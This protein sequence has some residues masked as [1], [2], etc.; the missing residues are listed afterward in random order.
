MGN[1]LLRG[2]ESLLL[3]STR[4]AGPLPRGVCLL[5]LVSLGGCLGARSS[6]ERIE[7]ER[8]PLRD[9][10][11]GMVARYH[12]TRDGE[13]GAPPVVE[14]WTL[15]IVSVQA[16]FARVEVSILG[17]PRSPAGPSPREPGFVLDLPTKIDGF[18]GVELIRLFRHPE[19]TTRGVREMLDRGGT[20][21]GGQHDSYP[22]VVL[23]KTHEAH[24]LT[25]EL[26]DGQLRRGVYRVVVVDDL[27]V[28]GIV[29]A[30]LEEV[31]TALTPDGDE[32]VERRHERLLLEK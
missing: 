17:P 32:V 21:V 20:S 19:L 15:S 22:L 10:R 8:S 18:T 5:A 16:G 12:A 29:E 26:S 25:V 4:R 3:R 6:A 7:L 1:Y 27:P 30:E 9:A 24:A 28:L 2:F 14:E 31:W 23:G 13:P 11:A